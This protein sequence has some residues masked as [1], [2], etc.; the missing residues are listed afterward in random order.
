MTDL[1]KATQKAKEFRQREQDI[2]KTTLELF[3]EHT[4]D[5]VTVEMIAEKAGIGKGTIYKHFET[6]GEICLRLMIQYEEELSELFERISAYGDTNL[7]MKEYFRFRM[8][9]P[10]RYALFDRLES[11]CISDGTMPQLLEKLHRIRAENLEKLKKVVRK[12]I[13]DEV[14]VDRPEYYHICAAWA[15]VHGAVAL[16]QS[17]FYNQV[18]Q[19]Q[20]KFLDFLMEVGARMGVQAKLIREEEEKEEEALS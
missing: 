10:V 1:A 8:A 14:L 13:E 4:E 2:L 16:H 6:K 20:D 5:K 18:I 11:K 17:D 12:R 3:L 9:D 15:L 19:D 7:L